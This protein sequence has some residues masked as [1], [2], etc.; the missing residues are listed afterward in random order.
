MSA[1]SAGTPPPNTHKELVNSSPSP[2][3]PL[4]ISSPPRI[5]R[6]NGRCLHCQHLPGKCRPG[7]LIQAFTREY[8]HGQVRKG[9]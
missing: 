1:Q 4:P 3:Q 5:F 8:K 2:S 9:S 6:K 7:H